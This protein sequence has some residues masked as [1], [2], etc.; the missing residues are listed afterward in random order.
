MLLKLKDSQCEKRGN[1]YYSHLQL[2]PSRQV[3]STD[4][5]FFEAAQP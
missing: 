2:H 1:G 5:V 4:G 3:V